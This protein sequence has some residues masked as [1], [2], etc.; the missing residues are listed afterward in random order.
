M[1]SDFFATFGTMFALGEQAGLIDKHENLPGSDRVL[2]VDSLAAAVSGALSASSVT[3]SI[4]SG[5][6]IAG[7]RGRASLRW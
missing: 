7:A 6:G 5:A 3:T 1:L 4:E 2:L